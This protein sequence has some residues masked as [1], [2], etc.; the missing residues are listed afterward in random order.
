MGWRPARAAKSCRARSRIESGAG[1]RGIAESLAD[2][3]SPLRTPCLLDVLPPLLAGGGGVALRPK[4]KST[5]SQPPLQAGGGAKPKSP[6]LGPQP[7]PEGRGGRARRSPSEAERFICGAWT[8]SEMCLYEPLAGRPKKASA[9]AVLFAAVASTGSPRSR[10]IS[11][12]MCL[13]YIGSLRR[14]AG[15]GRTVRGNR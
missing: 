9:V 12:Q 10:A 3:L 2:S 4:I 8:R 13:R 14:C 1:A 6:H 7:C 5:P 11:S 15:C